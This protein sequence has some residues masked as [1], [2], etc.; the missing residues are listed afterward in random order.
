MSE[1]E[2]LQL[3]GQNPRILLLGFKARRRYWPKHQRKFL[4]DFEREQLKCMYSIFCKC[5]DYLCL[6]NRLTRGSY[7]SDLKMA[8]E[9]WLWQPPFARPE[10]PIGVTILAAVFVGYQIRQ[11]R[12][13]TDARIV[14]FVE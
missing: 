1:T 3:I 14:R 5:C 11:V 4:V 9:N 2:Y 13:S 12:G 6:T 8:F 7:L 10:N